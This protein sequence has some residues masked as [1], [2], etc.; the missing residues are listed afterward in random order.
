HFAHVQ[1][2]LQQ[3]VS[4]PTAEDRENLLI[5]LHEFASSGIPD[6]MCRSSMYTN[7]RTTNEELIENEKLRE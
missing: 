4:A 5:E 6:V 2:R 1:L 3:V 7:D